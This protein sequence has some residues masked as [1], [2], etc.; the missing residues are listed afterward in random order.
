MFT[1]YAMSFVMPEASFRGVAGRIGFRPGYS[2]VVVVVLS[3]VE[4]LR[5]APPAA[6]PPPQVGGPV[7]GPRR[8]PR[9]ESTA[10]GRAE[11]CQC[12]KYGLINRKL[13]SRQ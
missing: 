12:E 6:G 13:L 3:Q 10:C 2:I 1:F 11:Q 4:L 8:P 9:R 5:A 7:L